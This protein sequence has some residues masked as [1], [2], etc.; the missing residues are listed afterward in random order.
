[1]TRIGVLSDTH[2]RLD[3]SILDH[4][5]GCDEIWHAGDI[6]SLEVYDRL[7][8]TGKV[9]RA[10][11]GNIDGHELRTVL[12]L[13]LEFRIEEHH[14]LMTHIAGYPGRYNKR[15]SDLIRE[16]RPTVVVCGHS[17]I[18]KVIYDKKLEH[19]H[20]NPGACGVQ[21]FHRVRTVLRFSMDGD[22]ISDMQV[23]EPGDRGS[24]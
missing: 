15:V 19:L 9:V 11:Y 23:I 21:G 14:I 17:H 4:L 1:M 8:A 24:L 18:L 12:P 3:D 13:D 2:G 16:I 7:V 10:V 6:G 5:S 22:K 20:I